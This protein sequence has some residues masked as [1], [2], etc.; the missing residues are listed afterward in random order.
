MRRASAVQQ[1]SHQADVATA[2]RAARSRLCRSAAAPLGKRAALGAPYGNPSILRPAWIPCFVPA[3]RHF[4][5]VAHRLLRAVR[6]LGLRRHVFDVDDRA[7]VGDEGDR[8]RQ[9]RVAH[10]EALHVGVLEH[11]QHAVVAGQLA[12]EH[13]AAAAALFRVG[14][15]CA[16]NVDAGGQLCARQ[17]RLRAGLRASQRR[18]GEQ[19]GG[20]C[21]TSCLK[22]RTAYRIRYGGLQHMRER[23]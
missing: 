13:Q 15:F 21:R 14:D 4:Q 2:I 20:Q 9:E 3:L 17:F 22:Q 6:I 12:A 11:E 5:R 18:Q 10:P 23:K 7:V 1:S 19:G 16:D 8:K